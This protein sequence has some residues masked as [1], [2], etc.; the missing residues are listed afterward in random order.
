[1]VQAGLVG[2]QRTGKGKIKKK[3]SI[4]RKKKET[5]THAN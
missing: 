4:K 5:I 1:L 2:S 3:I